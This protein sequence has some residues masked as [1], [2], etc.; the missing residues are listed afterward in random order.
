MSPV[1]RNIDVPMVENRFQK[2]LRSHCNENGSRTI[3]EQKVKPFDQNG[4]R[5][6]TEVFTL[7]PENGSRTVKL[8]RVCSVNRVLVILHL[9][10]CVY[11]THEVMC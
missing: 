4:S 7:S 6:K 8:I 10:G 3:L 1:L 5:T 2:R 11:W 9:P